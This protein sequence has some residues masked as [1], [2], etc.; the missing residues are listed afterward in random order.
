MD[1][2]VG[3]FTKTDEENLAY[4]KEKFEGKFMAHVVPMG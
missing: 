2:T 3:L 4:L 1:V